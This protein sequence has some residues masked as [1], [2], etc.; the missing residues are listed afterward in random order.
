METTYYN[1]KPSNVSNLGKDIQGAKR[2]NFDTYETTEERETRKRKSSNEKAFKD[3][4]KTLVTSSPVDRVALVKLI[5]DKFQADYGFS[6][7][8]NSEADTARAIIMEKRREIKTTEDRQAFNAMI[9][10]YNKTVK[11]VHNIQ[12]EWRFP[13]YL[14][15]I[16][17]RYESKESFIDQTGSIF[18]WKEFK[19]SSGEALSAATEFLKTNSSAVQFGNSVSDK[20]RAAIL[21]ELSSFIKAWQANHLTS[22]APIQPVNWSFGA[23]GKAGSVAYY[24]HSGKVVSVNRNNIGSLIHELGHFLDHQSGSTSHKISYETVSAYR[25]T[26]PDDMSYKKRA[27]Y[28]SRSEIFARAFEAYCYQKKIGF[29]DFAQSGDAF[30]PVLNAEL[31]A[32]VESALKA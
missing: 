9:N 8:Y 29:S 17:K 5:L 15:S 7:D 31:I 26:L 30:L 18:N 2:M 20:E 27:Y 11:D 21:I 4:F 19:E 14:R 28:S 32:L 1:A 22:A 13:R 16:L 12:C 6:A 10:R 24:Q 23:R 3:A 25:S